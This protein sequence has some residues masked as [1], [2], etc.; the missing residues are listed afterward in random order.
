MEEERKKKEEVWAI[1][2]RK[3]L[4]EFALVFAVFWVVVFVCPLSCIL[5]KKMKRQSEH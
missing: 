5:E 1:C 2:L 4:K 3:Y